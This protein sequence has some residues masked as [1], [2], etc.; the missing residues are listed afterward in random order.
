MAECREAVLT[1]EK[2]RGQKFDFIIRYRPDVLWKQAAS[3][4]R[5]LLELSRW[6]DKRVLL[7]NHVAAP[8]CDSF[9]DSTCDLINDIFGAATRD[10]A[11]NYFRTSELYR[12]E[13]CFRDYVELSE[14]KECIH[15]RD[16]LK[17]V[18]FYPECKMATQVYRAGG[19]VPHICSIRP[20]W[21]KVPCPFRV[22]P[23]GTPPWRLMRWCRHKGF[24]AHVL[25]LAS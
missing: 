25:R 13:L 21:E 6:V 2:A 9:H 24:E 22:K 12:T 17:A 5:T 15:G 16:R 10:V 20:G 4:P 7:G 18:P 23:S 19:Y 3:S 14:A 1:E 8:F 11:E